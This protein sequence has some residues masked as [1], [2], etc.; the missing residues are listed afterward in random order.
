MNPI[1]TPPP[2]FCKPYF[3][4]RNSSADVG[5]AR[6]S[7]HS[8]CCLSE[9]VLSSKHS[10]RIQAGSSGWSVS[11]LSRLS[12]P[13]TSS[14]SLQHQLLQPHLRKP[15]DDL[16]NRNLRLRNS[17]I[18]AFFPKHPTL[19][20]KWRTT[21]CTIVIQEMSEPQALVQMLKATTRPQLSKQ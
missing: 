10:Q 1:S 20:A 19:H 2:P 13:T 18:D 5:A 9:V 3:G 4:N 6:Y 8:C 15:L 14:T 12:H 17:Q 7:L 16:N 11:R 21:A